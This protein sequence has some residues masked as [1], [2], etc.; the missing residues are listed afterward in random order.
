MSAG[1]KTAV[2]AAITTNT[3][4]TIAKFAGALTTGSG[5]MLAEA[6]HSS[7]DV[8]NQALLALGMHRAQKQADENHPEGY[9]GEAFVWSLVSAVGMFFVGAGASVQHGIQSLTSPGHATDHGDVSYAAMVNISILTFSLVAE[10]I[11]LGIAIRGIRRDARAQN[12]G[13]WHYLRTTDDPFG[14]AVLMEDGAAVLGVMMALAAVILAHWTGNAWWDSVGTLAIGVL[15][16]GVACFLIAKNRS[17]LLSRSARPEDLS[18]VR[19][20]L[21]TDDLIEGVVEHRAIVTGVASYRI[22]AEVDLDGA[23]LAQRW[24]ENQ[25]LAPIQKTLDSPEAL[26]SFLERYT[27]EITEHLG[28]EIDRIESKIRAELPKATD[29]TIEVD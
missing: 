9:G 23:V 10:G 19:E 17:L 27:E 15:L 24:M 13:F 12:T 18:A 16:G 5:A 2:Y 28:D 7:A 25:D 11:C 3:V 8:G 29:I 20:L 26:A 14:V 1:S 22:T 4:V 6:Y 21:D